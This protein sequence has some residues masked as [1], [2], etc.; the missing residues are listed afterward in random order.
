MDKL[1]GAFLTEA[2]NRCEILA[3]FL[4]ASAKSESG[5]RVQRLAT[6]LITLE[7]LLDGFVRTKKHMTAG[8]LPGVKFCAWT[9]NKEAETLVHDTDRLLA[10]YTFRPKL[11]TF[12]RVTKH[13]VPSV[14][15]LT[16]GVQRERR[17]GKPIP[18][19]ETEAAHMLLF[20]A[21]GRG[22]AYLLQCSECQQ[23]F[24]D[25]RKGQEYC[26]LSCKK[27]ANRRKHRA[28]WN[29]YMRK[30]RADHLDNVLHGRV[31]HK[32]R[33]GKRNGKK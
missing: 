10:K 29:E 20:L 2:R 33:K 6:N 22:L 24:A 16:E 18:I 17:Y 31:R 11:P 32:P 21:E 14:A 30:Y 4:N 7:K 1:K 19:S 12:I 9:A 3:S 13:G 15:A 28:G 23:W 8:G 26:Q 27:K 5:A 25:Q